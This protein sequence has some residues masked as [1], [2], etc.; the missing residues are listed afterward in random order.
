MLP[1]YA[2]GALL[3]SATCKG[4]WRRVAVRIPAS[5]AFLGAELRRVWLRHKCNE[6][7]CPE[8]A[9]ILNEVKHQFI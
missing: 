8:G 4:R 7:W 9:G 5:F 3:D 2:S 6:W 1:I